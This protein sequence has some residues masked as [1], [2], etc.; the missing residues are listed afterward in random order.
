M[1]LSH[2]DEYPSVYFAVRAIGPKVGVHHEALR[3]W[4]A[5][6]RRTPSQVKQDEQD[7]ATATRIKE[8]E[9]EV[10]DLAEAN[11]ILKAASIFFAGELDPRRR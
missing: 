2:L 3:R 8:L 6:T 4:V 1:V 5:A 11:E 10:R 7:K 9:R